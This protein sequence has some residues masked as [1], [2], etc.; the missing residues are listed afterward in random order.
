MAQESWGKVVQVI[1]PVIDV[2][3][4]EDGLP[5]IYNAL[6][7]DEMIVAAH[8]VLNG[9]EVLAR[10]RHL[11]AVREVTAARKTHAHDGVARVAE[12]EVD[13]EVRRRAGVG[14][15]VRVVDSEEC[16]Q[17]LDREAL[18]L[19]D[20]L[21][22]FVIALAGVALRVL[23]VE[24]APT[25]LHDRL[26]GVVFARNQPKLVVLAL[27]FFSDALGDFGIDFGEG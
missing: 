20:V 19:V 15:D 26:A 24:D 9:V 4:E 22:P 21:L 17:A 25:G 27:L 11:P 10:D 14:L 3:Y 5:E 18:D 8:A 1:G 13:A 12:G 23:V 16:L 6:E 2:E 7:I